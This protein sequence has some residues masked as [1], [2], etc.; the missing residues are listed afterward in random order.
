MILT[1]DVGNSTVTGG[2]FDGDRLVL[3]FRQ[4]TNKNSTSDEIGIFLRTV[5]R[6]NGIDAGKIKDA[7]CCSVVPPINYSLSSAVKKY[8]ALEPLFIQSGIKTGLK[9]RYA[10]P[11][12]IGADRIAAAIGAVTRHPGR[13][14]I[15]I[16]MGTATTIDVVTGNK[17]YLGGAI[18]PGLK[19]S[20]QA[21]A[22]GTAK[23]P[24]V[25]IVRP[26]RICGQS[27][28][29]AIQSGI[30]YGNAGAVREICGHYERQI[31]GGEKPFIV[32]TGG[33]ARTFDDYGLFDEIVPELVL[34]GVKTALEMNR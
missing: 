7:C 9:I 27:T 28:I 16:D 21:L 32:G 31:F 15:V 22:S 14:L 8:F 33:F 2:V 34:S 24:S 12:E 23:L 10:N 13:N 11:K 30:F 20:V 25:E 6:E 3:Q 19:I 17:E 29:E 4:T 5:L 26:A 18:L 1:L